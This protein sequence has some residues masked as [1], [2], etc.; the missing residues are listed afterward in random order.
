MISIWVFIILSLY[1]VQNINVFYN[2]L[3]ELLRGHTYSC[4]KEFSVWYFKYKNSK[5]LLLLQIIILILEIKKI[6]KYIL[7]VI[8]N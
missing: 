4:F 2:V 8:K 5:Y 6:F 3:Y 7:K 1:Q